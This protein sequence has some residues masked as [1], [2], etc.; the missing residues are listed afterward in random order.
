MNKLNHGTVTA[1]RDIVLL[2]ERFKW[3]YF[4][5]LP[6]PPEILKAGVTGVITA[7]LPEMDKF[8]ISLENGAW[9]TFSITEE[10]FKDLFYVSSN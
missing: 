6:A 10:E 9:L 5:N 8:A 7:Y 1:K 2:E 4:A 3:G